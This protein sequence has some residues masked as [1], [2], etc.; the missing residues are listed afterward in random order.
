ML[1]EPNCYIR[2]CRHYWG[3]TRLFG[4]DESLVQV[5]AAYPN[6]IPDDIAYGPNEHS[7]VQ[8][9][10]FGTLVYEKPS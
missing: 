2:N 9:G 1:A 8:E 7:E 6:G 3:H 5:C 4:T 10:Q